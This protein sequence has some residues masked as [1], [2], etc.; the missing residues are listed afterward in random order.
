ML[1]ARLNE[2]QTGIK[3]AGRNISMLRNADDTT[4]TAESKE[5]LKN[6]LGGWK[7]RV[8]SQILTQY[9][10]TNIMAYVAEIQ[11]FGHFMWT[12]DSLEKTLMMGKIESKRRRGWQR[13]SW[14]D[15]ITDAMDMNLCKFLKMMM[16][17]EAWCDA[18]LLIGKKWQNFMEDADIIYKVFK[19]QKSHIINKKLNINLRWFYHPHCLMDTHRK[20]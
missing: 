17:W 16:D 20:C 5:V 2:L 15:G 8:K 18:Y 4:L 7:R 1:N 19:L 6:L 9:Q 12:A 10:K 11:Y 3:I 14:L 13:M